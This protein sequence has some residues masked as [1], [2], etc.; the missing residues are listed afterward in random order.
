VKGEVAWFFAFDVANELLIDK[1][2][3]ILGDRASFY[4]PQSKHEPTRGLSLRPPLAVALP[5]TSVAVRGAKLSV[6]I[7]LFD[8]GAVSVILKMPFESE[9]LNGLSGLHDPRLDDG[10]R[11]DDLA[12]A[13][14]AD[15][16]HEI[17]SA[18]I[19]ASHIH[20]PES[21]AVFCMSSLGDAKDAD[22]WLAEH[23]RET[24]AL[25]T[26]VAP[27][28]LSESQIDEVFRYQRSLE[29]TDA[30]IIGWDAALVVE[31]DGP[32]EEI[33]FTIELANL[34]LEEF[35]HMDRVLDRFMNT[36]Y[37]DLER[38]TPSPFGTTA[39]LRKLRWFRIDVAKLADEV[40][41]IT[42]LFG[43]WH[44]ARVYLAARERFHLDRWKDS[45]TQRLGQ[46][47]NLYN[48]VHSELGER[49]MFFLEILVA[50][51]IVLEIITGIWLVK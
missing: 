39:T 18:L 11:L 38:R 20:E 22:R 15:I 30:V 14:C 36:A 23:R 32:A 16:C 29:R 17:Q 28:R 7:R 31:L 19:F 6:Q 26:A 45:V 1:A 34:Q 37:S 24:A 33:L 50:V 43:D 8:F 51:L 5:P 48:L 10:R 12:M 46:L 9:S 41:N 49:R 21:Y 27:D 2:Q 42:K 4:R 13:L 25:L 3:Q 47:D 44:L 40:T 35:R